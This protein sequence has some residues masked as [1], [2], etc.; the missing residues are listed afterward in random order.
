MG[1]CE[2][3]IKLPNYPSSGLFNYSEEK[4]RLIIN[5]I[6]QVNFKDLLLESLTPEFLKLFQENSHLFYSQPFLNGVSYEY[7]LFGKSKDIVK[8][9]E[10]YK[11]A[12]DNKYDY[13]CMYRMHRIFLTD[14]KDFGVQKNGDLHRLYL[15]KFFAYLPI[16]IIDQSYYLLNKIDVTNELSI[17]NNEYDDQNSGNF[18]KF[19]SFLESHKYQFHISHNDLLLI[20]CVIYNY[21][22]PKET[23]KKYLDNLLTIEHNGNASYEARLKYCNF[24]LKNYAD[25]CDKIK[26]KNIFDNLIKMDYYKACSDYG[27]FLV[28]EKKYDEAKV[29]FKKG[30]DN[31]QQFCCQ[32]YTYIFLSTTDYKQLLSDYNIIFYILKN[33][34]ITYCFLKLGSNS[35]LYALYYLIKHSSFKQRL[36]N[37]FGKYAIEMFKKLER[38]FNNQSNDY[39]HRNF[40][41]MYCMDIPNNFGSQ[42]FYGILNIIKQ[43]RENALIYFKKGYQLSKEKNNGYYK[44]INYLYIYKCRKFL[45]KNNK[46]T[47]RKLNKTK[48]KLLRLYEESKMNFLTILELYNYYKLY[49]IGV[50]GNTQEKLIS[51]L[52]TGKAPGLI[53]HFIDYV[54]REKCRIALE[55]E[56]SK[57]SSSNLNTIIINKQNDKNKINIIFKTMEN[58][59]YKLGVSKNLQFIIA[60]HYLYTQY[61]ELESKKIGTY[62]SNGNKIIIFDTIEENGLTEGSIILI[63]N[64]FN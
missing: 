14:Y 11:D 15:Y 6:G 60:V 13:L 49:K 12:A 37:D 29:I 52:K 57:N 8:A 61:P 32:Q 10:I 17:L 18:D 35:F 54:S 44:R 39:I 23:S 3:K 9:F 41:D 4:E 31:C 24:Y 47:V 28:D 62:V 59:Q 40:A 19:I 33:M 20:K 27:L 34:L 50:N 2:S 46:L 48:E 42:Y 30:Y 55:L 43:D 36:E 63:I 26:I 53:Y 21:F 1:V 5:S 22:A 16:I 58:K 56:Y 45:L 38:Y 64:K 51:I 7:G 25:N